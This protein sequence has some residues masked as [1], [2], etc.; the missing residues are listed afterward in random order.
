MP[1]RTAAVVTLQPDGRYA[2]ADEAALELLGVGSV[3]ELRATDPL[4]FQVIP[5]DPREV[6]AMGRVF[7]D[8]AF[9]GLLAE[10]P[11][12]RIDGELVRVRTAVI[13]E[14]TGYRALFYPVERPT[15][16]LSVRVY[17]IS[18]VLAEWR[19]AERRLAD[20]DPSTPEAQRVAAEVDLLRD[21]YQQLFG[22]KLGR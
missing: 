9:Q 2:D 20:L 12:K 17:R 8:A 19:S 11:L 5:P 16:N 14:T 13:P 21:Q 6:E 3:D 18:D 15:Q 7:A 4:V 1:W 22:R 10:G